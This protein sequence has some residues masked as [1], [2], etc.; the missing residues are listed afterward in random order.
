M[1][2]TPKTLFDEAISKLNQANQ[3]LYRPEE[4]V[5]N[6]LVCQNAHIAIENY[7]KG[8]LLM[9]D[10][11]IDNLV[12]IDSLYDK[13]KTVNKHFE[14]VNLAGFDCTS[15]EAES[16]FCNATS[17]VSRCFEIANSLDTFLRKEKII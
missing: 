4:D 11:E 16:R 12:T 7:L 6:F 2:A 9:H 14:D 17:K 3:E 13:C 1:N 8:F 10:I 15:D 5:V